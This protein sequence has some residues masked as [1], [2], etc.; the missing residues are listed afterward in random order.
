MN[1]T[2]GCP[3]N[4]LSYKFS[5]PIKEE[6]NLGQFLPKKNAFSHKNISN[7]FKN[8]RKID[9]SVLILTIIL[10]YAIDGLYGMGHFLSFGIAVIVAS[11]FIIL[12]RKIRNSKMNYLFY[13]LMIL[14][15][16]WHGV[17]KFSIWKGLEQFEHNNYTSSI[18]H[19]ERA[20]AMY[21]KPIGRFH[22][23]LGEMYIKTGEVEKA[24]DHALKAQ[25]INPHHEAP[26][27]LLKQIIK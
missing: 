2:S 19:L 3:S 21:P 12:R 4:A 18:F 10:G 11:Q 13:T 27:E 8:L 14:T 25:N 9:Y 5:N 15:F 7:M 22:V 16:A 24:R 26:V 23:I 17:V 20:V 6:Y 1:C